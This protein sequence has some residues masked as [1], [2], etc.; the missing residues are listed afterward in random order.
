MKIFRFSI[1][2]ATLAMTLASCNVSDNGDLDGLWYLT[3]LDSLECGKSVDMRDQKI[4]WSFQAKLC[5]V[6]DYKNENWKYPTMLRFV[7]Q[8]NQ[9]SF[10]EA[11]YYDRLEGDHFFT[12]ED[13]VKLATY[14]IN[15]LP[16]HFKVE[17]LS[18]HKLQVSDE[19]LRLHFEKY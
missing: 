3:R 1:I 19:T 8:G 10:T 13:V 4:S 5:Q 6:V 11:F 9:L 14:G 12:D 16:Q 7:H 2:L 17:K 15:A 18:G